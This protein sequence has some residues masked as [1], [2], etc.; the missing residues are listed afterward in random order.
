MDE[1]FKKNPEELCAG[2]DL[3]FSDPGLLLKAVTHRSFLHEHPDENAQDYE[4][5]EFLG[6]AVLDLAMS[7]LLMD[8]YHDLD[9]GDLSKIRASAVNR[10]SLA[11]LAR[12]LD[13]GSYIRLSHGEQQTNGR[14]KDSI[15]ADVFES[16]I[17]AI[18]MEHGFDRALEFVKIQFADLFNGD[19][20]KILVFDY[21]TRLQELT[22]A[23]FGHPP[24]YNIVSETGPD[25]AKEFHVEMIIDGKVYGQ[26]AGRTKKDA[27][28]SAAQDAFIQ[29]QGEDPATENPVIHSHES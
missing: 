1:N 29:L 21:K 18:Y 27:E 22:Q 6:D 12:K 14:D 24:T 4:R 19:H 15:L 10:V 25:H 11:R 3:D 2:L 8:R 26:G 13:L 23:M 5:L 17:G 28:Q 7:H 16:V 9:A 20:A